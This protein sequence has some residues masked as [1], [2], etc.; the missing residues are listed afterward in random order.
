M[1]FIVIDQA[2]PERFLRR[3]LQP[4]VDRRRDLEAGFVGCRAEPADE[5]GPDHLSDIGRR[6]L[7]LRSV[8]CTLDR[9]L[10]CRPIL[11]LGDEGELAHTAE[12]VAPALHR[13][14][15]ITVRIQDRRSLGNAGDN[16]G[17]RDRELIELLVKVN[18]RG[19][20]DTISML[21]EERRI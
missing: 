5:L 21:A 16:R 4:T 18:L 17:L 1:A 13:R 6:E 19:R 15:G 2:A 3:A 12:H 11:G 9:C 10:C 7:E 8:P 20:D 14:L